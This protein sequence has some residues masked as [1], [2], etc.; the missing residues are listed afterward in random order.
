MDRR[1]FLTV[2]GALWS[3]L[4]W[5]QA[6][7][8]RIG[9]LSPFAKT[10]LEPSIV[11]R[12]GELGYRSGQTAVIEARSADG[13]AGHYAQLAR[14]LLDAQCD[15]LFAS[16]HLATRA[17]H[18]SGTKVPVVFMALDFDPVAAGMVERLGRPGRNMT[19]VYAPAEALVA[20]RLEIAMEVLPAARR[21]L[22]LT[23]PQ[24]DDQLSALGKVTKTR[25]VEIFNHRF[26]QPPFDLASA[27]AAGR[28]SRVDALIGFTSPLWS[29][30]RA[31]L[32]RLIAEY[33]LPAFTTTTLRD[34]PGV[35]VA[36]GNDVAKLGRRVAEL[37]VEILKGAS[38]GAIPVQSLDEYELVVNLRTAKMLGIKVPYSVLARATKVIE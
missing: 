9:I 13:V 26:A 18:A 23:D 36:F 21:F 32:A 17:L 12:L 28:H 14:E 31:A 20:K 6:K 10:I 5:P 24:T 3:T 15:L 25:G 30:N 27:F 1:A 29:T 33:R 11:A 2:A 22:V 38:P 35:L 37:G 34:E 8:V 4:G 7:K 16:G 19:G